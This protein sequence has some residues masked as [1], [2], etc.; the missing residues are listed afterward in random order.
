[1]FV[2][3]NSSANRNWNGRDPLVLFALPVS[4]VEGAF[5]GWVG[6]GGLTLMQP[7][8]G[9]EEGC[10]LGVRRAVFLGFWGEGCEAGCVF[11]VLRVWDSP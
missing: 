11:G 3:S 10:V 1:M 6:L 2:F 8:K 9:W 7:E 5:L 4:R